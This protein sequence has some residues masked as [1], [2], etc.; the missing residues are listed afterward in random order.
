[1]AM[2]NVSS[3]DFE[4]SVTRRLVICMRSFSEIYRRRC[5]V[6]TFRSGDQVG[7]RRFDKGMLRGRRRSRI[8]GERRPLRD[9]VGGRRGVG[10]DGTCRRHA[11]ELTRRSRGWT[12]DRGKPPKGIGDNFGRPIIRRRPNGIDIELAAVN[13]ADVFATTARLL[14]ICQA[15]LERRHHAADER[16]ERAAA[17]AASLGVGSGSGSSTHRKPRLTV[18][19]G[20]LEAY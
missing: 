17:K 11:D 16:G 12:A 7:R 4:A 9:R 2:S 10:I 8:L 20:C 14:L 5:A 13:D 6:A 18:A 1:M 3:T 19:R 15:D